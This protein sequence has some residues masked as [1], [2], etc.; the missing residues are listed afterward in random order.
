MRA[1]I[2]VKII[3]QEIENIQF[4]NWML[5]LIVTHF[6]CADETQFESLDVDTAEKKISMTNDDIIKSER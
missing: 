3:R 5:N 4:N 1:C 6:F 2:T